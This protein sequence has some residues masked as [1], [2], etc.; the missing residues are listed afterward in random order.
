MNVIG[1]THPYVLTLLPL[2]LLPLI[3]SA[4]QR[5]PFPAVGDTPSDPVSRCID[6]G[7]RAAA[8]IAIAATVTA[9]AGP[10]RLSQTIERV[11]EGANIIL[12]IDRSESMNSTFAGRRPT[13]GE[14]S[15]AA[16]S[17]RLIGDFVRRRASDQF[18]V[19]GFST[20]PMLIAPL[21]TRRDIVLGAIDAID[22][23]GLTQTNVG[24]GLALALSMFEDATP[25]GSRAILLVSDGA[26]VID[27]AVQDRIRA[28]FRRNA[29]SL[30]WLF[31]RTEGSRGIFDEPTR[32]GEDTPQ[33]MPERHLDRFFRTLSVPYRA[34]EAENEQA[35][36]DAI[37]AIDRLVSQPMTYYETTPR[38]DISGWAYGLAALATLMVLLAKLADTPLVA[39]GGRGR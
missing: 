27:M 26:A 20:S 38:I 16:T 37:E 8:V 30:Y 12:L 34:F 39:H 23:P 18:G 24:I 31:L 4:L 2:A 14:E 3:A 22:R 7:I 9:L 11:G 32:R 25:Q 10:H 21:T 13:G 36:E 28:A 29:T 35:I 33:A 1:F 6:V 17:K 19:A 5:R 15:K